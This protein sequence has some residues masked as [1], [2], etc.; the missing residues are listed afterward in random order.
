M[1]VS[2][3]HVPLRSPVSLTYR[4]RIWVVGGCVLLL[5][6]LPKPGLAQG[7]VGTS[8][9]QLVAAEVVSRP[10]LKAGSQGTE[11]SEL[12]ATLK[13]LG[14]YSGTVDG[15]YGE[16]TA[17]AV[18]QFQQAAGLRPDGV[19]GP[20]TWN[21]LFPPSPPAAE[22]PT[23]SPGAATTAAGFPV[24]SDTTPA[25][26]PATGSPP[27]PGPKPAAKPGN[28]R[29]ATAKP[30]PKP[31]AAPEAPRAPAGAE[32]VTLPVLRLGMRG[33]AVTA[34]QERLR[35]IGVF[36]GAADGVFG[37]E[38]Q[39]AVKAAQKRFS[40]EPDGVVGPSTWSAL[41]R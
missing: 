40:L 28:T 29:P 22:T 13:L 14:Y 33:P 5:S 41:L 19:V 4:S 11:V 1:S 21:R 6:C 37:Q 8:Q 36:R 38:T 9:A 25:P 24:P 30:N 32:P 15:L 17:N 31:A 26:R 39:T 3:N 23:A 18:T 35:A 27:S 34:L 2:P 16:S 10:T 12:Q 20:V 7:T